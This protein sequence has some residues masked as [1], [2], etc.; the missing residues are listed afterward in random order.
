MPQPS[1]KAPS[2]ISLAGFTL[3]ELIVTMAIVAIL[4]AIAV[5][6]YGSYVIKSH[7]KGAGADLV[8]LALIME[9]QHQLTLNYASASSI[10]SSTTGFS[11]FGPAEGAMFTYNSSV[12]SA[13]PQAYTLTAVG[14][15]G[16]P[17][18]GCTL[19]LTNTNQR[20]F[21]AGSGSKACGGLTSW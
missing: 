20:T 6:I 10:T 3:V 7:V 13:T 8:A 17:V 14:Q 2:R 4:T 9:N 16:K 12:S 19:Q 15:S 1:C 18:S 5:P 21:T 11:A